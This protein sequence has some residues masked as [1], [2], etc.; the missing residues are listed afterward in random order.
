M[1]K[2]MTLAAIFAAVMMGISSCNPDDTKP[3][4]KPDVEQPGDETPGDETP[5]DETPGD[6]TPGDETP[7]DETPAELGIVIDGEFADWEAVPEGSL[8]TATCAEEASLTALKVMKVCAD[9]EYINVY[10]EYDVE[11]ITDLKWVPIHI[12]MDGDNSTETG[13]GDAAWT[14][15]DAEIMLETAFISGGEMISWDPSKFHWWEAVGT[16]GW[17]WTEGDFLNQEGY[18]SADDNWGADIPEGSGIAEGAGVLAEGKYE[19]QITKE[20][21]AG[22][23]WADTIGIGMDI[24]QNWSSVG[25][26]PNASGEGATTTK[27]RVTVLK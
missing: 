12:Y 4:Q 5:G 26:L 1:K 24:Q 21:I 6:E 14:D 19:L 3:E 2:L 16:T 17:E 9:A 20:M 10:F 22:A 11:Q 15:A 27:L 13:G 25:Q 8:F 7:G 23:D 18:H